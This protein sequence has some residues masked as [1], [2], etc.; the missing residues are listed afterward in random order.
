[1]T[2]TRRYWQEFRCPVAA[3]TSIPR[4]C[5]PR[6]GEGLVWGGIID[7]CLAR[8][9]P[10]RTLSPAL[11][12]PLP[13][14]LLH[15]PYRPASLRKGDRVHCL[16]RDCLWVVTT[17]TDTRILWQ[18]GQLVG[19]RGGSGL[20][21]DEELA[22]VVRCESASAIAYW[23][24]VSEGV[25]WRW[26]KALGVTRTNN[27]GSLLL[28]HA[29]AAAGG[30]AMRERGLSDEECD[31]RSRAAVR[32]NL[33]QFLRTGYHG[34]RWTQEQLRLLGKK[35]DNVVAG[36][37]GRSVNAVRIMRERLGI[38]NP[39]ARQGAY[40]SPRWSAKQEKPGQ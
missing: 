17:W 13:T 38:P 9:S 37:V 28:I 24:R 3:G 14:Q 4:S 19:Q 30:E 34:P 31:E 40:G 39:A 5:Q 26:R 10:R 25:V 27:E 36:K 15:G 1:M 6:P 23:W 21:L 20:L 2:K 29:A 7:R 16:L 35:P 22:R 8:S 11:A 18:R 33:K 12:T 32:L